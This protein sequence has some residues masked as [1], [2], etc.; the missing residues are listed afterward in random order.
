MDQY[1]LSLII[2]KFLSLNY[3]IVWVKKSFHNIIINGSILYW[4]YMYVHDCMAKYTS[5]VYYW[6]K[7]SHSSITMPS[8]NR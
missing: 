8:A 6:P 3:S 7:G 1:V 5:I 4:R 2:R